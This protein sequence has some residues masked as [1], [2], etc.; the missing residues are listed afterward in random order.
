MAKNNPL[1]LIIKDKIKI[2]GPINISEF[3]NIALLHPEH[4]YYTN[5]QVFGK[6]GDFI[7][8]PEI[9]Q[10]FGELIGAWCALIWQEMG[11]PS[12]VALVELGPGRGTLMQDVMRITSKVKGFHQALSINLVEASEKLRATQK[13]KLA[14]YAGKI[15][16]HDSISEIQKI[17]S[18]IIANE[19]FDALPIQ[20]YLFLENKWYERKIGLDKQDDLCFICDY[21]ANIA[22]QL[23]K[24]AQE[25]DIIEISKA[26]QYVMKEISN[27]INYYGG[28]GI[29]IDYGY[30][31]PTFQDSLQAVK[32]HK[33]HPVLSDI[34]DADITAHVDFKALR[35]IANNH[36]LSTSRIMDQGEFLSRM[37]IER[38][39]NFLCK[40]IKS[41]AE[42]DK[43]FSS[44]NRLVSP[45]E[46]GEL[47]KVL[48]IWQNGIKN[49]L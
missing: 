16:W 18:I 29:F 40:N 13:E 23:P 48:M 36:E 3:M 42:A 14:D 7:T 37:G 26:S 6:G 25:N 20:Q 31:E 4:G 15:Y 28:A 47:F 17:P 33:F 30:K 21:E 9:S 1:E 49:P 27:H 12:E 5:N 8:A 34:G 46:M 45:N 35:D 24:Q 22:S 10:T 19:F 11:E 38:R 44:I 41:Q 2:S 43:I 32:S 39:Y